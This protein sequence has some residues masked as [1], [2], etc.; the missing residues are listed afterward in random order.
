[1]RVRVRFRFNTETGE[2]ELFQ[3]DDIGGGSG[4]GHDAEHDRISAELG[5]VLARRPDVEEV[6]GAEEPPLL[7]HDPA[8]AAPRHG[9]T[10]TDD[11]EQGERETA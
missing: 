9:E 8:A 3:V 10:E 2:V 4:A 1:M 11:P 7:R 6:P 5:A